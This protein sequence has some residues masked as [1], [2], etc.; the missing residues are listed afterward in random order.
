MRLGVDIGG[1]CTDFALL[2]DQRLYELKVPTTPDDFVRGVMQG[3]AQLAQQQQT[4]VR[5]LL[6][7]LESVVH[8][9][10]VATNA[11]LTKTTAR[12]AFFT[13]AGHRD[14]LVM[15]EAGRMGM[16]A[17]DHSIENPKPYV[18]R[19]LTYEI[20]ER[21]D[22]GGRIVLALDEPATERLLDDL[23][24]D[25]PAAIA[26]C[27]LWSISN[28]THE[29][30]VAEMIRERL[31]DVDVSLS[32]VVNPC[33]REYR[34][35]SSTCIDASLKSLV[36]AYASTLRETLDEHGFR[37]SLWFATSEGSVSPVD[38]TSPI[39]LVR[40]GPALGPVAAIRY[41]QLFDR[42]PR[43]LR[44]HEPGDPVD[45]ILIDVGG[46]TLD[47]SLI[48]NAKPSTSRET[49]I[50]TPYLG[51]MTGFPSVDVRSV[52]AGGGSIARVV[53]GQLIEV[54]PQSAG[55]A[56]GPACYL[57]GGVR[58]TVMDAAVVLGFV[59]AS[60]FIDE[61]EDAILAAAQKALLK[62][63][64]EPLGLDVEQ[65]A[66]AVFR[67]FVEDAAASIEDMTVAQGID[68]RTMSLVATGGAGGLL[69]CF[70]ARRLA[71]QRVVFP[72]TASVNCAAGGVLADIQRNFR[73]THP[74]SSANFDSAIAAQVIDALHQRCRLFGEQFASD[75]TSI[76]IEVSVDARY[77]DQSWE[78]TVPF[79]RSAINDIKVL[80][81]LFHAAHKALYHY[82]DPSSN[83]EFISWAASATVKSAVDVF[84]Y[85]SIAGR[86]EKR[87][88]MVQFP[89]ATP[90]PVA[91]LSQAQLAAAGRA[92]GPLVV[93]CPLTTLVV[94]PRSTV[95]AT[96]AGCIVVDFR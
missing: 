58:A 78:I 83:I 95:S 35:A 3:L 73:T 90:N 44:D 80:T 12:S 14:M 34:R 36:S 37:G 16:S 51:H 65:A 79:D 48:R 28:P 8:G 46:T 5:D 26:V 47:V 22:A 74:I 33:I 50:G 30:R 64:G 4:S 69:A 20:M 17:F 75:T 25:P 92:E 70:L 61:P 2:R 55:A 10:T 24:Q 27:L 31:P 93:E 1:T 76:E 23:V 43:E 6:G 96:N 84:D 82:S 66:S 63:V 45:A 94:P 7:Q 9:T 77:Q 71:I 39:H 53:S 42:H 54:G 41:L 11:L 81:A 59:D 52:G 88:R 13:T 21:V 91:V 72:P 56:P 60:T 49:W 38:D 19:S 68:P 85:N 29:L 62:D 18:P 87:E 15:R 57:Q 89:G 86:D 67:V 40:S 32:H